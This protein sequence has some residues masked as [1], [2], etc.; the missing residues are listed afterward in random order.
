[1]AAGPVGRGGGGMG[2]KGRER[3]FG[4]GG[5]SDRFRVDVGRSA[6]FRFVCFWRGRAASCGGFF[7]GDGNFPGF[8]AGPAGNSERFGVR[9][10]G[11][12]A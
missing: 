9:G 8:G 2:D 5:C 4:G 11:F 12:E 1:M 3:A 7:A 10:G 6:G